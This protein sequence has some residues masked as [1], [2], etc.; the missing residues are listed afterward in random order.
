MILVSI[1]PGPV[2]HVHRDGKQLAA[3]PLDQ[4]SALSL[5]GDIVRA[6]VEVRR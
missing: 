2:L 5:V 1:R 4:P 3:V 6:L